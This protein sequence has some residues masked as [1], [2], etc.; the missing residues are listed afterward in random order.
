MT[1]LSILESNAQRQNASFL[2]YLSALFTKE[3]PF[4]QSISGKKFHAGKCYDATGN[5]IEQPLGSMPYVGDIMMFAGNFAPRDWVFC[6]GQL[7]SIAEND[8]LFTLIGTI[9]GGDGQSNFAVPDLRA[10]IPIGDGTGSGLSNRTIGEKAGTE[11][12]YLAANQIPTYAQNVPITKNRAVGTA[13]NSVVDGR[14]DSA[15]S[16]TSTGGSQ[17]LSIVSPFMCINYC[18]S[19]YGVYPSPN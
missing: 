12:V 7:L 1:D 8:T 19:L 11:V 10:R 16:L 17:P 9:Y 4:I 3:Q 15:T 13:L 5:R 14:V 18:I 2:S 6:Q